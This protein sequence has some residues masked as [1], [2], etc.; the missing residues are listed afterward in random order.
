[1]SFRRCFFLVGT[2]GWLPTFFAQAAP[3]QKDT[4]PP[5][6][7]SETPPAG[8]T[9]QDEPVADGK[10]AEAAQGE[11]DAPQGQPV[12][13]E[14]GKEGEPKTL[15]DDTLSELQESFYEKTP[16]EFYGHHTTFSVPYKH[17][18]YN[19]PP[20]PLQPL[21]PRRL[22]RF[23]MM[24]SHD[25]LIQD[26]GVDGTPTKPVYYQF[27]RTLGLT[28]GYTAYDLY[29]TPLDEQL[30]YNTRSPHTRV[31]VIP[32]RK[33]SYVDLLYAQN[34]TK[35]WNIGGSVQQRSAA[36]P[37][38]KEPNERYLMSRNARIFTSFATRDESYQVLAT[39]A[40]MKHFMQE[41][42]GLKPCKNKDIKELVKKKEKPCQ[43]DDP[44]LF[45]NYDA[46]GRQTS[47]RSLE[48][49]NR[50]EEKYYRS[51]DRRLAFNLYQQYRF[52]PELQTYWEARWYRV[53]HRL[54]FK[55]DEDKFQYKFVDDKP[56][57]EKPLNDVTLRTWQ[58]ELGIKGDAD[59][60]FYNFY[61][62][63]R[64]H[65]YT[66]DH[67]PEGRPFSDRHKEEEELELGTHLRY[68]LTP[69]QQ[70]S[71]AGAFL[72]GGCYR[73]QMGYESPYFD[74]SGQHMQH[75]VPMMLQQTDVALPA[76]EQQYS[77]SLKDVLKWDETKKLKRP[78]ASQCKGMLKADW[79]YLQLHPHVTLTRLE[80]AII[81]LPQYAHTADDNKVHTAQGPA[82][83]GNSVSHK[84]MDS[85]RV[86]SV[87]PSQAKKPF[88]LFHP[89]IDAATHLGYFHVDAQFIFALP[90][91]KGTKMW[92]HD[93]RYFVNTTL[94]YLQKFKR[95]KLSVC[96][97][98]DLH[99]RAGAIAGGY[100]GDSYNPLTQQYFMQYLYYTHWYPIVD[101][102]FNITTGPFGFFIRYNHIL[103]SFLGPQY[104]ATPWYFGHKRMFDVGITWHFFD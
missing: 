59:R 98:L 78:I 48:L 38:I 30:Y 20:T 92:V 17:I 86:I 71:T 31:C 26:L 62:Q 21:D 39:I 81:L 1:M 65:R 76:K 63:R 4:A 22:H 18:K 77:F 43:Y 35:R 57:K 72:K 99:W 88:Y 37:Y 68:P 93:P 69:T 15:S 33:R 45:P 87:T 67:L 40:W 96:V 104:F 100:F 66:M 54:A 55:E 16:R 28:T 25:N 102:F 34:V 13:G 12:E 42:G 2:F 24:T 58:H 7:A 56:T 90:P 5:P 49:G 75:K 60:L 27:P 3:E 47:R 10:E 46:Q 50:S 6:A 70:L 11:G 52:A 44:F 101:A 64:D 80:N 9:A 82:W 103:Q 19:L 74:L 89:G 85:L 8:T 14:K 83:K 36:S 97:G 51:E 94:Y 91:K 84:N 32:G 73:A 95:R 53:N 61:V 41:T 23:T 29:W 79:K